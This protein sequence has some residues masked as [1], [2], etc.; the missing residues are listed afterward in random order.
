MTVWHIPESI[1]STI[2]H[3]LPKIM[4][5]QRNPATATNM[6]TVSAIHYLAGYLFRDTVSGKDLE[7]LLD[8]LRAAARAR[9]VELDDIA[10]VQLDLLEGRPWAA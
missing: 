1:D 4:M 10:H 8:S 7:R 3:M 6:A 9:R 5:S 2:A